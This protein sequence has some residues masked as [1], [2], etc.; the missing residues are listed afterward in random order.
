MAWSRPNI[1]RRFRWL[2][3][4]LMHQPTVKTECTTIV[5]THVDLYISQWMMAGTSRESTQILQMTQAKCPGPGD[6]QPEYGDGCHTNFTSG[7]AKGNFCWDEQPEWSTFRQ[8]SFGHGILEVAIPVVPTVR[9]IVTFTKFEELQPSEEFSTPPSSPGNFQDMKA[10]EYDVARQSSNS[11]FQWIKG[12]Y[13]RGSAVPL[14]QET[15]LEEFQDPFVI[16]SDY[17]WTTMDAKK[18]R[19]KEKKVR[20][21]RGKRSV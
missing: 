8:S 18:Q 2:H 10:K 17:T 12:P 7:P 11:W 13:S 5:W 14:S 3:Q 15:C 6:N 20:T 16:P 21:K 1:C 4:V 19:T 9:V